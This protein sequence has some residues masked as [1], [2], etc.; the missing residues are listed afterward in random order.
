MINSEPMVDYANNAIWVTSRSNGGTAQPS[1]WKLDPNLGNG[2][3]FGEAG[4]D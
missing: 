1:L 4:P 3:L 2:P